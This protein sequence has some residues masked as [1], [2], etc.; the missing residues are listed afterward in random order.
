MVDERLACYWQPHGA[1]LRLGGF[2]TGV[3]AQCPHRPRAGI[4]SVLSRAQ[5]VAALQGVC[6][7]VGYSATTS[8]RCFQVQARAAP[9]PS[10]ELG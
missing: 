4:G 6:K 8:E 1:C 9:S 2:R 5:R 7:C 10:A 3:E